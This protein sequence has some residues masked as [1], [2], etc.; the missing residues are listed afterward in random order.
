MHIEEAI[1]IQEQLENLQ[2]TDITP[3]L[4]LGSS[5]HKFRT[6]S[7]PFIDQLIFA[8]LRARNLKIIHSDI[9]KDEGVDIVG[10][11]LDPSFSRNIKENHVRLVLCSNMLEHVFNLK[12]MTTAINKLLPENGLL[13]VTVPYKYPL[14]MDPIDTGF[15]PTPEEISN[16]F[17][18]TYI[19]DEKVVYVGKV[20]DGIK[21][22]PLELP[23]MLIRIFLPFIRFQGWKTVVNK[24]L[25]MFKK[26][27]VSCVLLKKRS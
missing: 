17:P 5:T 14:H 16:L 23:R 25:W 20:Y 1:W 4:N 24:L 13:I 9:K 26:R 18:N 21:K 8:P 11:I 2:D 22:K 3:L 19:M 7:Q 12:D 27:Y 15:R 6:E 10:N